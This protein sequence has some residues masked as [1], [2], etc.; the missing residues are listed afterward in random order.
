V[1]CKHFDDT[2][3]A[4]GHKRCCSK[5]AQHSLGT[6]VQRHS[7]PR[8]RPPTFIPS[9]SSSR[10]DAPPILRSTVACTWQIILPSHSLAL[11]YCRLHEYLALGLRSIR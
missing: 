9:F 8:L 1:K 4:T 2:L 6:A 7:G 10:R 3:I 5:R 11:L